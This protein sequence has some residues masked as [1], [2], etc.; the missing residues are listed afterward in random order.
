MLRKD[1]L[2]RELN[3]FDIY[4]LV[5]HDSQST[6]YLMMGF[7]A[8]YAGRE[9][10]LVGIYAVALM[11]MIA[12]VYGEMG[13]H[14]PE[15]GGSYL[16][17]KYSMGRFI[18]FL[19]AWFLAF[20][21]IVMISYGT[22]DASKYIVSLASHMNLAISLLLEHIPIQILA[23]SFSTIL[24]IL[25]LIGIRE[26]ATS[27]KIVAIIDFIS[28]GLLMILPGIIITLLNK[29]FIDP[30]YFK[31]RNI[32]PLDLF[33][34]LALASR[35][36]T[37][38]DA[39]GQ[40]AGEA[41][42]PLIQIPRATILVIVI[43][44]IYSIS[45]MYLLMTMVS[46]TELSSDPVL[47]IFLIASSIPILTPLIVSAASI[48]IIL[49]M[50]LAA[51]TGYVSFSRLLYILST[52]KVLPPRLGDVHRRFRTPHIALLISFLIST[53]FLLPGEIELIIEPYAIG[54]LINYL[55]VSFSLAILS[56]RGGLYGAFTSPRIF[57]VAIT[58][59]LGIIILSAALVIVIIAKQRALLI[60]LTWV[61]IGVVLYLINRRLV[62]SW[63]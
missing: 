52:D 33:F 27:A 6:Y 48:N 56:K 51:L 26:S 29:E 8:Y 59:L 11:I 41:R 53:L 17:V 28:V 25:T 30:P 49:I 37:G 14:F 54:S 58:A 22:L 34:A 15:S 38:I 1:W 39:L 20:D 44:T 5:H 19:S 40:L 18:G 13:S 32:D 45:L 35:G 63:G 42:K 3:T 12:L 47:S 2:R 50:I 9:S 43:G 7:I 21:Q 62:K 57:G 46:Y 16:Y 60:I 55:L 24:F 10:F 4:S 23:I 61:I 36:F 31:W